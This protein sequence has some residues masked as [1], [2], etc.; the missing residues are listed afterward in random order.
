ME[1]DF[2]FRDGCLTFRVSGRMTHKDHKAFRDILGHIN[3]GAAARVVF[4]LAKVEF[5]DSS[6]LGMLLIVRDAVT[7]NQREVVL[8]GANGQVENLMKVAKL[9]KYFTVE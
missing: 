8:R 2:E 6:A 9:H 4:D 1:H 7:Q 5:M 3:N